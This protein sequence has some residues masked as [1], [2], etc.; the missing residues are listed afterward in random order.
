MR[1]MIVAPENTTL[2]HVSIEVAAIARYHE[3]EIVQGVVRPIDIQAAL[4]N[5]PFDVI[6]FITHLTAE[7]LLLS[8]YTLST[9]A[10]GGYISV[11]R[12]QLCVLNTCA[13]ENFATRIVAGGQADMIFTI[14]SDIG[15]QDAATFGSLLAKELS[16]T[17]DFEKAFHTATGPVATKYRYLEANQATRGVLAYLPTQMDKVIEDIARLKEG[18]Y[19]MGV[20]LAALAA[21]M[22]L[23]TQQSILN[24]QRT[25][26]ATGSIPILPVSS[27]ITPTLIAMIVAIVLMVA[28]I[29][30]LAGGRLQ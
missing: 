14:S 26:Q 7:G 20:D 2:T 4:Q 23:A 18:Q 5:G 12:A 24:Q 22:E 28:L 17:D 25:L 21:R 30:F 9:E 15:D 16:E 19:K 3:T 13:S 11:S 10:A 27:V 1:I 6:W 8:D 29:A